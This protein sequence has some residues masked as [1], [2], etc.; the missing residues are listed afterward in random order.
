MHT[1]AALLPLAIALSA[2]VPG[3]FAE[4]SLHISVTDGRTFIYNKNGATARTS[5]TSGASDV[6]PG[7]YVNDMAFILTSAERGDFK[8]RIVRSHLF[9]LSEDI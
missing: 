9:F 2:F 7:P 4:R 5:I 8:V 6:L 1:T 3:A